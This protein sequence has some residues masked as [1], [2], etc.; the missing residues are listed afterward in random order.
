M[1]RDEAFKEVYEV[2][3]TRLEQRMKNKGH[4]GN[5]RNNPL[6]VTLTTTGGGKSFFLDELGALN[7][8]DLEKF[9]SNQALKEILLNSVYYNNNN[10]CRDFDQC[11][12]L[13]QSHLVAKLLS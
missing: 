1:G 3:A 13:S 4:E 8:A 5:R 2:M 10:N 6:P 11:R 7:P 9:C 12:L